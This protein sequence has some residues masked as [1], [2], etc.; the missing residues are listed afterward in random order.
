MQM[1]AIC[2]DTPSQIQ[3]GK[4][5]H[6]LQAPILSDASLSVI[7][8]LGLRN[9][10]PA[11][12]PPGVVGLPV[13]TTLFV[14]ELGIVRWKDQSTDYQRRSNPERVLSGLAELNSA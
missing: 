4:A 13:P 6:G 1:I 3:A 10:N 5:K 8:K 12:K 14:D 9:T 7:D 11:V 2:T